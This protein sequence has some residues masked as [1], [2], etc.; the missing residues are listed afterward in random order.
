MIATFLLLASSP[1]TCEPYVEGNRELV[2]G[3]KEFDA[4]RYS[5]AY[6]HYSQGLKAIHELASESAGKTQGLRDDSHFTEVFAEDD[7]REGRYRKAARAL[8]AVLSGRLNNI[9]QVHHCR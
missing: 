5:S 4:K 1:L 6:C 3:S 2:L 8:S 9:A 7:A